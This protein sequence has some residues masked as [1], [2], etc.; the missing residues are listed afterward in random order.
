MKKKKLQFPIVFKRIIKQ[1]YYKVTSSIY[2]KIF[3]ANINSIN[4]NNHGEKKKLGKNGPDQKWP[5][6][7]KMNVQ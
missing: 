4:Y 1:K 5:K 7:L 3:R 2:G 6:L